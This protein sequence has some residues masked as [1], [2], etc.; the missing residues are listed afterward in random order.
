MAKEQ[1]FNPSKKKGV[2][3]FVNSI[4]IND[5]IEI[6]FSLWEVGTNKL[7]DIRKHV[8]T[9]KYIGPTRGGITISYDLLRKLIEI[10]REKRVEIQRGKK[11]EE[12]SR[13]RKNPSSYLVVSLV[14]STLD[15]H[16]VCV[17]IREYIETNNY[18]G[19][20]KKGFRFP[21]SL[22]SEFLEGCEQLVEVLK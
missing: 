7:G 6:V 17:D 13:I 4:I 3:K 10:L 21:V 5:T 9:Q 2:H 8:H 20:T 12:L 19:P 22:F 14:E 15:D 18:N 11:V 1:R 16:P